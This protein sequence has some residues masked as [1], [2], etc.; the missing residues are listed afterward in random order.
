MMTGT[1]EGRCLTIEVLGADRRW[2]VILQEGWM[3]VEETFVE[4]QTDTE[5][6]ATIVSDQTVVA[7][8]IAGWADHP[9]C[10]TVAAILPTGASLEEWMIAV[11]VGLRWTTGGDEWVVA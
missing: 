6:A 8:T 7:M 3:T 11:P 1:W 9:T 4:G 2:I 10:K 5:T